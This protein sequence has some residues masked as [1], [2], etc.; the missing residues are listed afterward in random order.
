MTMNRDEAYR[1]VIEKVKTEHLVKHMLATEAVM[2]SLAIELGEDIERWGL[3]GLLHDIDIDICGEDLSE[4]SIKSSHM[5][6]EMGMDDDIVSAIAAHNPAHNLPRET[7]LA[8]A[9]FAADPLTGLITA[10]TLVLPDKKIAN[11]K[12]SSVR[13]RFK[14]VRFAA[15]ANREQM[16]SC[17]TELGIPLEKF[18]EIGIK[19]MQGISNDLGL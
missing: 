15:N 9:L 10:A 18:I 12:V 1:H 13:K 16:A 5:A 19:A 8:K 11:L 7:K 17:D 4:H 14:E 2:R 3:T 6:K